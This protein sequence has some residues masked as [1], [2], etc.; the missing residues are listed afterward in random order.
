[1]LASNCGSADN[2]IHESFNKWIM[3]TRLLPTISMLL[4]ISRNVMVRIQEQISKF[5]NHNTFIC[6]NINK[7]SNTYI[8]ITGNSHVISNTNN[9]F[10]DKH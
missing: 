7:K 3:E 4:A 10:E 9:Y 6:P 1:M 5:F 8:T 2:I